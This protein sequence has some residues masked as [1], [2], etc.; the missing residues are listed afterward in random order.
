MIRIPAVSAVV[1][2][3]FFLS[4]SG[5]VFSQSGEEVVANWLKTQSGA[6]RVKIKF[7]QSRSLKTVKDIVGTSGTIYVDSANDR[8]RMESGG[9]VVIGHGSKLT[10]IRPLG[11]KY[12]ERT[13]GNSGAPAGISSLVN[14]L[15]GS[16][17]AF[18]R[19]YK[20]LKVS[21]TGTNYKILTQPIGANARGVKT[22]TFTVDARKYNLEGI[23][24]VLKDGSKISTRFSS[25]QKNPE[26]P[27][28]L[29]APDLTGYTKTKFH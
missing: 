19:Q 16:T 1:A 18:R 15:P 29:F 11:K 4:S 17:S 13:T 5:P 26:M 8:F 9:T 20:V 27:A 3:V 28:S 24:V 25:I 6:S 21:P 22:F 10:V 23:E 12:E 14:G 2:S 7:S